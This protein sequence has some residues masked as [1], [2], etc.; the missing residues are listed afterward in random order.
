MDRSASFI[1]GQV[2]Q[3]KLRLAWA[4]VDISTANVAEIEVSVAGS[5]EDVA[6]LR[7]ELSDTQLLLEQPALG[8]K[9]RMLTTNRWMHIIIRIPA[10]WRGAVDASTIS[11]KLSMCGVSGT[12]LLLETISGPLC[13]ELL[14]GIQVKLTSTSGNIQASMLKGDKLSLTTVSGDVQADGCRF[15]SYRCNSVSGDVTIE[16]LDS[17]DR[18]SIKAVSGDV[19][20][21]IPYDR[22]DAALRSVSGRVRTNYVSLVDNAP[23][24]SAST[25]SGDLTI[26]YQQ[27]TN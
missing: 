24:I 10:A 9:R 18:I 23:R 25:V 17:F 2:S 6:A 8:L 1:P 22:A 21:T 20:L 26:S 3:M 4:S 13:S 16:A 5:D 11:G 12:D 15:D 14:T 19:Q 27:H 7:M